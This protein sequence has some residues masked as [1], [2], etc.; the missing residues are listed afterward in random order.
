MVGYVENEKFNILNSLVCEFNDEAWQ[1]YDEAVE[2]E[3]YTYRTH[4][5]K[6]ERIRENT[7]LY[8]YY[9]TF[10]DNKMAKPIL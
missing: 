2:R 4:E 3:S 6:V 5:E 1:H 7:E 9:T 10:L 8:K